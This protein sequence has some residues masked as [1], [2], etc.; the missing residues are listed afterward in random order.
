MRESESARAL[1]SQLA[2]TKSHTHTHRLS[3]SLSLPLSLSF[4]A[5][6]STNS[7]PMTVN[8]INDAER[9]AATSSSSE[10]FSCIHQDEDASK[11]GRGRVGGGQHTCDPSLNANSVWEPIDNLVNLRT[12]SKANARYVPGRRTSHFMR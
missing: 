12:A 11:R 6:L 8:A 2:H 5:G 4:D 9:D 7:Q 10:R 3:L 1:S